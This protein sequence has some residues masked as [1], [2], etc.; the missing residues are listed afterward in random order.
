[1][2]VGVDESVPVC[3]CVCKLLPLSPVCQDAVAGEAADEAAPAVSYRTPAGVAVHTAQ[4]KHRKKKQN[5]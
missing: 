5:N 3:M 4:K 2:S 1:M